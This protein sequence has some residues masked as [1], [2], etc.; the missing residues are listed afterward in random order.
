VKPARFAEAVRELHS[1]LE[2]MRS[3]DPDPVT[4]LAIVDNAF[5]DVKWKPQPQAPETRSDALGA[6]TVVIK[7]RL[8]VVR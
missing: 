4:M 5:R 6:G 1:L 2:S 8:E 3:E 7:C